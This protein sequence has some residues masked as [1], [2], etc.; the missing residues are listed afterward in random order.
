[1]LVLPAFERMYPL[2]VIP[3]NFAGTVFKINTIDIL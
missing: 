3:I 1:M 2:W